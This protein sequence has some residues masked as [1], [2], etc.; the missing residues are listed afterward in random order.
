[1]EKVII[2]HAS[3]EEVRF[4]LIFNKFFIKI[5]MLVFYQAKRKCRKI[6]NRVIGPHKSNI[7]IIVQIEMY[8]F[9]N[10]SG[11]ILY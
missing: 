7:G 9:V 10:P 1:M 3:I 2:R 8:S 6:I 11:N 4:V 5:P